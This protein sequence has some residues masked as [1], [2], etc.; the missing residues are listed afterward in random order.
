MIRTKPNEVL[1]KLC[2]SIIL[3]GIL[4]PYQSAWGGD[5]T[6]DISVYILN[7]DATSKMYVADGRYR[8]DLKIQ[9]KKMDK[10]PIIIVNRPKGQ[11]ILLNPDTNTY[12]VFENFSFRAHMVDPFQSITFLEEN[13]NLRE[14]AFRTCLIDSL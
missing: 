7:S 5:F 6:A 3:C 14:R 12:S 4:F 13:V 10:G 1:S 11:T 8:M 9:E 2:F